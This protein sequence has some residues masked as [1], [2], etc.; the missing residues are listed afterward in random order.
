MEMEEAVEIWKREGIDYAKFDFSCG[1]DSMN[2]TEFRFYKGNEEIKETWGLEAYFDDA[3]YDYV[4]FYEVS[5]GHYLG[6]NGTV[7][8]T[9]NK[10]DDEFDYEKSSTE[11]WL[12]T[13]SE[14]LKVE[15]TKKQACFLEEYVSDM[16]GSE[17]N[18]EAINYKKDFIL[19][20]EHEDMIQEL[21][22]LFY[23]QTFEWASSQGELSDESE[24][25]ETSISIIKE[26]DKFFIELEVSCSVYSYD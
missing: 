15:I 22:G 19:K 21:H 23:A 4:E 12:E 25:Y 11:E 24:S 10:Y 6:E 8:I 7:T 3:I 9:F 16:S 20:E 1:G 14:V 2:D 13:C 17:W 26:D 5:D 18:G